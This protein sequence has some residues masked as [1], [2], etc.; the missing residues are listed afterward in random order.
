MYTSLDSSCL[1]FSVVPGPG[2]Q[3]PSPRLENF[4]APFSVWLLGPPIMWV[5]LSSR[6]LICFLQPL[7]SCWFHPVYLIPSSVFFTCYS[8]LQLRLVLYIFYLCWSS[9]F[10]LPS[11]LVRIFMTVTLNPFS[12]RLL[13]SF[14]LVVFLGFC[15][16]LS[17]WTYSSV[18]WFCLTL[19]VC[20]NVLGRSA[21]SPGFR[22]QAFCGIPCAVHPA[23]QNQVLQGCLLFELRVP[24]C[25][26]WAWLLWAHW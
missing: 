26:A 9:Q 3:F 1:G 4:S 23:Q 24:S 17:F 18:P 14:C 16:F 7:I 11:S 10:T 12:G 19:H 20:Y 15:L 2:C 5:T 6:L 21:K 25:C 13:T 22:S 8:I